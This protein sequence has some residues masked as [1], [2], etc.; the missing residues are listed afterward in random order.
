LH[1]VHNDNA[2][3]ATTID[4]GANFLA[5][6]NLYKYRFFLTKRSAS[7]YDVQIFRRT[8]ATGVVLAS[9]IYN[10]TTNLPTSGGVLQQIMYINNN[11]TATNMRLGDYGFI[12]KFLPL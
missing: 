1:I 9:S 11:A 10:L 4:L 12:N 5:N 6:S 3:A 7:D 2:G 8:L